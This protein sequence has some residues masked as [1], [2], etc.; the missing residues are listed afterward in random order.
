MEEKSDEER[1]EG[2][3]MPKVDIEVQE[4]MVPIVPP[5]VSEP[6]P[7]RLYVRAKDLE[8]YGITHRCKGCLAWLRG[9]KGPGAFG[10]MQIPRKRGHP[11]RGRCG[12]QT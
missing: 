6:V 8:K 2:D 7:R 3:E 5:C 12:R 10:R 9:G 11:R 1:D 4:P